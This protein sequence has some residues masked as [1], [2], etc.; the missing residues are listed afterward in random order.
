MA[1]RTAP[2]S[3]GLRLV[4]A[5]LMPPIYL[6]LVIIPLREKSNAKRMLWSLLI[7]LVQ[8]MVLLAFLDD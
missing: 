8:F 1:G 3:N 4:S 5:P 2:T 7:A 6:D